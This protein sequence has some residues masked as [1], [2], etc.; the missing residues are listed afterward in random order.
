MKIIEVNSKTHG[1]HQILVDDDKYDLVKGFK[2]T[3]YKPSKNTFHAHT[4]YKN[5]RIY[6]HRFLMGVSVSSQYVD[7]INR[8]GLDNRLCNLRIGT[9]SQNCAN[10]PARGSVSKY[11]GVHGKGNRYYVSIKYMYEAHS[12]GSFPKTLELEGEIAA[13]KRYDLVARYFFGE[14]AWLNFP[15]EEGSLHTTTNSLNTV[16]HNI[17]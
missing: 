1:I 13:A 11:K 8:N 12:L 9:G 17:D 4:Q 6:L 2:W 10:V 7:H 16:E 15:L 5:T 14:F 3:I